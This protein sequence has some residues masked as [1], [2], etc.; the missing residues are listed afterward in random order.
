MKGDDSMSKNHKII[1][2]PYCGA[3]FMYFFVK[4]SNSYFLAIDELNS[5]CKKILKN[6]MRR[7]HIP[8]AKFIY[9]YISF[10]K[11]DIT[12]GEF[13]DNLKISKSTAKN[14]IVY[15][16]N[17]LIACYEKIFGIEIRDKPVSEILKMK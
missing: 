1:D 4:D 9:Y 5:S 11:E 2:M 12:I 7:T 6:K 14:Y 17:Y 15:T 8:W 3:R 16:T 10:C 13:A